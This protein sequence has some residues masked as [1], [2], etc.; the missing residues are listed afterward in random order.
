MSDTHLFLLV[1]NDS[2]STWLQNNLS[3]CVNCSSFSRSLDGK[4]VA[5]AAY[6]N[7]EINKLFS[8]QKEMWSNPEEYDWVTIKALW[9]EAWSDNQVY[10]E[11]SPQ[12]IY[13]S[14][15]YVEHFNDVRFIISI[16][17]PYAVAEGMR[18][19]IPQEVEIDR[20]ARH[21]VECAKQQI[22]NIEKY[23]DIS[24]VT[25]YEDIIKDSVSF[26]NKLRE[27]IP[28]LHD[29][30]LN[31][32]A[33]SHSMDGLASQK[34][35]DYNQR[36]I[37]NLSAIDIHRINLQL[38][39]EVLEYFGY[40]L[41]TVE[42]LY[43]VNQKEIETQ[44]GIFNGLDKDYVPFSL[45]DDQLLDLGRKFYICLT[46]QDYETRIHDYPIDETNNKPWKYLQSLYEG[47]KVL[48]V[49]TGAGREVLIAQKMGLD[50]YGV[51][52][53]SNN[54]N[55]GREVLGLTPDHFVNSCNELLPFP[56]ETFDFV[57]GFQ[58]LEH[59]VSP[60][61]FL[62]EQSRVLKEGGKIL[63]EWPA[64]S[65]HG[66]HG[67]DP[68]HQVCYTPGQAEGLLLKSGFDNISLF[69]NDMSPI[70]KENYWMGE[71]DKGYVIVTA[72]KVASTVM[73]EG[74]PIDPR[75][76]NRFRNIGKENS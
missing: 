22:A 32:E 45:S 27:L 69:Y 14:D 10:L 52:M 37:D 44:H 43:T 49:G 38:E 4:G 2:G 12:A 33:Q 64:A 40:E 11:K 8:E 13:A 67:A 18:R 50:A 57:A 47:T 63:L 16:R 53:G 66:T 3:Q 6:P 73:P 76:L 75:Y 31:K 5:G 42:P 72:E 48:F 25:T 61:L 34:L 68:Q 15:M 39:P 51:T 1:P 62:L 21:W 59:A 58:I 24:V 26:E 74:D 56:P 55:F 41:L 20:C 23:S 65:N 29:V 28:A 17:N 30:D 7:Q 36:H 9:K 54:I 60:L 46:T 19:T 71:Q 70:P 35:I